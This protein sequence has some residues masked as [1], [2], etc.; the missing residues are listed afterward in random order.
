M[1]YELEVVG[2]ELWLGSYEL[3]FRNCE[4][5]DMSYGEGVM[6][7]E[8]EPRSYELESTS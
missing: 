8:L 3:W 6:S 4:L 1:S 5:W 7:E 2:Y